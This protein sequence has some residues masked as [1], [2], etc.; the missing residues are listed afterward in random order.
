[1]VENQR[2]TSVEGKEPRDTTGEKQQLLKKKLPVSLKT[3]KKDKWYQL[4]WF[5]LS[6]P[7]YLTSDS[8]STL[9]LI[10]LKP[11]SSYIYNL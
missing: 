11:N 4:I 10:K 9:P 6:I 2:K 3:K 7:I 1:M 8:Y 5:I